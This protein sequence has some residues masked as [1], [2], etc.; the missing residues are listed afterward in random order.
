MDFHNNEVL[1]QERQQRIQALLKANGR[2]VA[3]DLAVRFGV[4]E[5]SI[6]R[7]LRDMASKGMCRKV[8][9]GA[10]LPTAH[11]DA[12]SQRMQRHDGER[13]VLA[14]YAAS[15]L[16][17]G[18]TVLLD[19]GSTN[20]EIAQALRGV[21]ITVVTNAPTVAAV[22]CDD[23]VAEVVVIGGRVDRASGGAIGG[24]AHRQLADL[25]VDVCIPGICA[26]DPETGVW[27][28]SAEE[29]AF[30]QAMIQASG[31]TIIVAGAGKL[32]TRAT[33]RIGT[34]AQVDHLVVAADLSAEL[35]EQFMAGQMQLHLVP[36]DAA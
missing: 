22:L 29:A 31:V 4:S 35:R 14:R 11:F 26:L 2:V 36:V 5:D 30:K 16:Q 21:P 8:Y 25:Q 23:P 27:G 12:L 20:V 7:D 9:G 18:Q 6:R 24:S 13:S 1:P 17:A 34:L 10:L 15:L 33:Y 32:G 28:N 3:S 19:A